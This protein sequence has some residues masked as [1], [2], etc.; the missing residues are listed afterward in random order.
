MLNRRQKL[1]TLSEDILIYNVLRISKFRMN[2]F[3]KH[4]NRMP[5]AKIPRGTTSHAVTCDFQPNISKIVI[6]SPS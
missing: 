2:I 4:T 6:V 1:D 3:S 5:Y